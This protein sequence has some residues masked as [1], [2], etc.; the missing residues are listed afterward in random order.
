MHLW[1]RCKICKDKWNNK[2]VMNTHTHHKRG[3]G[4]LKLSVIAPLPAFQWWHFR[5]LLC[6]HSSAGA[7]VLEQGGGRRLFSEAHGERVE[8]EPITGVWGRAPSEVHGQSPC[9]GGQGASPPEAESCMRLSC[10]LKTIKINAGVQCRWCS[11][12]AERP[13]AM[14]CE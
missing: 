3:G 4:Q 9:L 11:H 13:R 6:L 1:S 12:V 10:L 2:C 14:L 5:R 8:R 7:R